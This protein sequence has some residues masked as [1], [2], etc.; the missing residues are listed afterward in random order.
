MKIGDLMCLN[1]A[2]FTDES[3]KYEPVWLKLKE[4]FDQQ[5]HFSWGFNYHR[6]W[7]FTRILAID[8]VPGKNMDLADWTIKDGFNP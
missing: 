1:R 6:S 5:Q 3:D 4:E 8:I 7:R 2:N